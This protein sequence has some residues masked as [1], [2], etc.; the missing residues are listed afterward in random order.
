MIRAAAEAALRGYSRIAPTERGGFRLA[1]LVR[2]TRRRDQWRDTF[3]TPEGLRFKLD[4]STYPDCCMAYGV[5][6]LDTARLIRRLLRPGDHF[7]DA[8]ANL[9]YFTLLAA[10]LVGPEGRVDAFEPHPVNRARL[11]EHLRENGLSDRVRVHESALSDQSG[12]AT[13][14]MPLRGIANHGMASLFTPAG[15]SDVVEVSTVRMDE[16]L[17]G[18]CPTLIKMDVEGAEPLAVAGMTALVQA[19]HP[20]RMI[21]EYNV[22]TARQAGFAPR[23]FIDRLLAL[24]P[25][26]RLD[27]IGWRLRRVKSIDDALAGRAMANLFFSV[28]AK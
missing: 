9:G 19:E 17:A 2:R 6:E 26:Y 11:I 21:A 16:A 14:H 12:R 20:P 8:G 28:E 27:V 5:Y 24:Q 23:E 15:E 3:I 18:T 4:L 25:A 7:V 13:I 10:K 22:D 1:R